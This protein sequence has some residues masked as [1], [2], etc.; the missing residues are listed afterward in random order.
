M[1]ERQHPTRS[2]G[3]P[4]ILKDRYRL[5]EW[6]GEGAMAVVYRAYDETLDREV[7]IKFLSPDRLLGPETSARFLREARAVARLSHPNIMTIYDADRQGRWHYLVLE[8]I[9]GQ[10]LHALLVERGGPLPVETAVGVGRGALAA[11]A[12]AHAQGLVHRDIKPENIMLTPDGLVKVTDFGLALSRGDVRLTREEA[13][14]GTVLYMAP[15]VLQGEETGPSADLYA[16]GAVLYEL[17]TGRPPF[18]AGD[19]LAVISQALHAPL[20]PPRQIRASIPPGLDRIVTALLE[21]APERRYASAA[22]G[23]AALENFQAAE[24]A[25]GVGSG[26]AT[27]A[28]LPFLARIVRSSSAVRRRPDLEEADEGLEPAEELLV[29]A[30]IEDTAVAVEAER[31]RLARLLQGGVIESLNLLLSQ[32][33][34]YEVSLGGNPQVRLALNLLTTL[35]RQTLQQVRDL[36]ARL[37]P[38]V[39]ENLG[40]EPALEALASQETRA[41]GLPITL[42]VER[43]PERLPPSVELALFRAAQDALDRAVRHAHAS[44][45][46]IRLARR[47]ERVI[48]ACADN[49]DPAAGG[50]ALRAAR[51]RI[52]QLGGAVQTG[53][54][55]DGGLELTAT[56]L[57]E[58]PVQLTPR[59]QEVLQ[60]LAE[61]LTNKQIAA[62][63]TISPRTVNFHLDNVYSKLGVNSRTE[64]AI[65]ALRR[66]LVRRPPSGEEP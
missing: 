27:S 35:A 22:E 26:T 51:Q 57:V 7:A 14:V 61:G 54:G 49:G 1:G 31:R 41:H 44:Q 37:H 19:P 13:L 64:A 59:E 36:E 4:G 23:L 18:V 47:E 62:A 53:V 50:N 32:V 42:A 24:L 33:N 46:T 52:E 8:L 63:L 29:Y 45:A 21:K 16:V 58:P 2:S 3:P 60:L 6:L 25:A 30:A 17:L 38:A 66:G 56:F 20:T 15:E 34:A 10:D 11:L 48:F 12:Y 9:R 39:L 40:L 65:Y 43:L 28:D 5:T 55:P